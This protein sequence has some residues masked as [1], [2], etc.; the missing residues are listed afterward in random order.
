MFPAGL[1]GYST[2]FLRISGLSI[3][4]IEALG[5]G[6]TPALFIHG[7]G[8]SCFVWRRNLPVLASNGLRAFAMD[9]PGHG[10]SD[11][12]QDSARYTPD[13]M[14]DVVLATLDALGLERAAIVAHSLGAVVARRVAERAP[15]RISAMVLVAPVSIGRVPIVPLA[16]AISP[17]WLAS[18]IPHLTFRWTIATGLWL[19]RAGKTT[20]S[21]R[22]VDEYWA[23][24]Q[25]PEM[26]LAAVR[27]LHAFDWQPRSS[28]IPTRTLVILAGGDRLVHAEPSSTYHV[29]QNAGHNVQEQAPE[30]V[31]RLVLGFLTP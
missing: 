29:V 19:S 28:A 22:E 20:L 1:S 6:T 2:R 21:S 18:I 25:F 13:A 15:D 11:K 9:L 26:T 14:A 17:G 16:R 4:V 3:R 31:N 7:W 23:P 5:T 8:C 24:T 30:E 27:M 12:P 10:L